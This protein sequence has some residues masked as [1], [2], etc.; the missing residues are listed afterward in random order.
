MI[1]NMNQLRAFYTAAKR[2]SISLAAQELM[3]TPPAITM[4]IKK[5]EETLEIRLIF[6]HGN[7]IRLTEVGESVF[8]RATTIF[9]QIREME[10]YLE[11]IS[12]SKSGELRIGCPQTSAKYIMPRLI[13]RFKETYP[14]IRIVLSLGLGSELIENLLDQKD[15]LA[16]VRYR[17]ED[18]RLKVR[19][20][21]SE[22]VVLVS[23]AQS[24]HITT[25]EI[26][27]SQMSTIPLIVPIKGSGMRDVIFEYLKRFKVVPNIAMESGSIALIKELILQ[28]T[29]VSFLEKYAVKEELQ[30]GALKA[31]RIL[32]GSPSI[33][34]GIGYLKRKSFSSSAWA[35]LRMLD[36]EK[37]LF[38]S[39][40]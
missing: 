2:N 12:T 5:L 15:E 27:I 34:F 1:L 25:E 36:K 10:N 18:K 4:Q 39:N 30:S 11:D 37:D 8:Q 20:I 28:D 7:A 24:R 3:V 23:A 26:S 14:G 19:M 29:G 40:R 16:W 21:G 31:V 33:Q 13:S 32:E 9:E 22:G 6:R 17:P 35:F 38:P